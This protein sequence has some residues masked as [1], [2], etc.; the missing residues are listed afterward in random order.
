MSF[1]DLVPWKWSKPEIPVE[2]SEHPEERY[3]PERGL[4]AD[5]FRLMSQ[6]FDE[7]FG[8][9]LGDLRGREDGFTPRVNV[10][11]SEKEI[12]VIA[13]LPG[14]DEKDIQ[15]S[16]VGD[17]LVLQGQRREARE[18]EEGQVWRSESRYGRF[19]RTIPLP[20]EVAEEEIR[21]EYRRGQ[22]E[23]SLPKRKPESSGRRRR[24]PIQT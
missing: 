2:R 19:H 18:S 20:A 7:L 17:S 9:L 16:L 11:D 21:A 10:I 15:L 6:S 4:M 1:K 24:I 13:E 3:A 5:P 22:L 8:S 23:V 14:M 12:R